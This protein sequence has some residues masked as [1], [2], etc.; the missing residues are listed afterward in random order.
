MGQG[1]PSPADVEKDDGEDER[2]G[3]EETG[4]GDGEDDQVGSPTVKAACPSAGSPRG[5][6]IPHLAD[7]P[8]MTAMAAAAAAAAALIER[9]NSAQGSGGPSASSQSQLDGCGR[10]SV[11]QRAGFGWGVERLPLSVVPGLRGGYARGAG[12]KVGCSIGDGYN[13]TGALALARSPSSSSTP[14]AAAALPCC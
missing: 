8:R 1:E 4:E 9:E 3:S 12:V 13:S 7:G 6:G 2:D 11:L 10:R 14:P 5:L